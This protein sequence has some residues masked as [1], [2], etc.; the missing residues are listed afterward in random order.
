MHSD[1][2]CSETVK[3]NTFL[4]GTSLVIY[5]HS[6][7]CFICLVGTE[8]VFKIHIRSSKSSVHGLY[9]WVISFYHFVQKQSFWPNSCVSCLVQD[10]TT[11]NI[12]NLI[13]MLL[14]STAL[15]SRSHTFPH[16]FYSLLLNSQC[17]CHSCIVT[18]DVA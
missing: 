15:Q 10:N 7:K 17:D 3:V 16:Y 12:L 13:S 9:L 14:L 5:T 18:V 1:G 8:S 11:H 6:T 2:L 4:T